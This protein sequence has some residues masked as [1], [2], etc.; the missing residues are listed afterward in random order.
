MFYQVKACKLGENRLKKVVT[1]VTWKP[2]LFTFNSQKVKK[3][4]PKPNNN[5]NNTK[6]T[7]M[8]CIIDLIIDLFLLSCDDFADLFVH[9]LSL[10]L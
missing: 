1:K 9:T 6:R 3:K 8:I 10:S 2:S 4:N 5:N 7:T